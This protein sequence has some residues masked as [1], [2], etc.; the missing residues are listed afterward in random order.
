MIP[1]K[2]GGVVNVIVKNHP[3]GQNDLKFDG[4]FESVGYDKVPPS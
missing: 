4:T 2:F 1:A 3:C